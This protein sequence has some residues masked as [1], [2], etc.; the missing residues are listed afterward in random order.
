M[1]EIRGIFSEEARFNV[2]IHVHLTFTSRSPHLM[3]FQFLLFTHYDTFLIPRYVLWMICV[4]VGYVSCIV[5]VR[6]MGFGDLRELWISSG[7]KGGVW[8][9]LDWGVWIG[10]DLDGV[11]VTPFFSFSFV[12]FFGRKKNGERCGKAG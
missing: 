8:I 7:F 12:C 4:F 2:C 1:Y 5:N 6:G 11:L 10:L 3:Y 9:E